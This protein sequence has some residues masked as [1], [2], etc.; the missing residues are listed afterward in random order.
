[1]TRGTII[2]AL[3]L[4]CIALIGIAAGVFVMARRDRNAILEGF[5]SERLQQLDAAAREIE[6]DFANIAADLRFASQLVQTAKNPSDQRHALEALV[7]VVREY[8][9]MQIFDAQGELVLTVIDPLASADFQPRLY[10][11]MLA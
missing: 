3:A 5:A 8:H 10:E 1:M 6:E 7:A 11:E 4:V 2:I 9:M